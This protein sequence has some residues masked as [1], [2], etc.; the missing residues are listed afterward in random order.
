MCCTQLQ[1]VAQ[2]NYLN[3]LELND[4]SKID[5]PRWQKEGTA[6]KVAFCSTDE[7]YH[8]NSVPENGLLSQVRLTAW[9]GERVNLQ[10]ILWSTQKLKNIVITPKELT[11]KKNKI[12]NEVI[13]VYPVRYVLTDLFLNGCGYRK[14]DTIPFSLAPDML[15]EGGTFS[16]TG[17]SA[18]PVWVSIDVPADAKSGIYNGVIEIKAKGRFKRRL[19]YTLEVQNWV[20][21]KPAEWSFHLDLWQHPWAVARVEKVKPWSDE[22]LEALRSNLTM[23]AQAGQKCI[24]TTI[25]NDPWGGQTYD[26]YE[27]MVEWRKTTDGGWIYDFTLFDQYVELAMSCG[28]KEQINCYS[29]IPWTNSYQYF[30]EETNS[31]KVLKADPGSEAFNDHW[32]PFL[33]AFY[34]HLQNKGWLNK[35]CIA[36][37]ERNIKDMLSMINLIK[38][39]TP[40]MKIAFA[41]GFHPELVSEVYDF[42]TFIDPV[43]DSISLSQ[44]INK[45]WPS[46]FYVCCSKPEHPNNFTFSPS[47]ENTFMGWYAAANGYNGFL[48]WAFNSWGK[49]PERDSRFRA[50]PAGDTYF[51]YPGARSSVRFE[52]LREGIQDFEKIRILRQ[53]LQKEN[54]ELAK[55]KLFQLSKQLKSFTLEKVTTD[56]ASVLVN[57]A[58]TLINE[59][60]K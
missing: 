31:I 13:N 40:E 11:S 28:I 32:R 27:S 43:I 15:D 29:M 52:R 48:R 57:S 33:L 14:N 41:G 1:T 60:S 10:I 37:D 2:V 3:L 20:L 18:R 54:T 7:L 39:T 53:S 12:S 59:L 24:T 47:A 55:T 44:R 45:Q 46:T 16:I 38:E 21:S 5:L 6:L 49:D 17:K 23:L 8:R 22:H 56:S 36:M 50:W 34:E 51:V 58:R 9:K 25:I 19:H 26:P 42:C 35:T 30:D 4:T